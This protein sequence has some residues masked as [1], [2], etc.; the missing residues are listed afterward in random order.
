MAENIDSPTFRDLGEI[1]ALLIT[2]EDL[3]V[4]AID[5]QESSER[6]ALLWSI[7]KMSHAA[8]RDID[9]FEDPDTQADES[10]AAK[11]PKTPKKSG[12]A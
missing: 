8:R 3:A 5:T 4:M 9:D 2:I 11:V 6:G 1:N 10:D 7:Q 12:A